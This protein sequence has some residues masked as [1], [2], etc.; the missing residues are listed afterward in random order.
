MPKIIIIGTTE[1]I[2]ANIGEKSGVVAS[3][4]TA[5]CLSICSNLYNIA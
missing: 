4:D 3:I 2:K 5:N 1:K